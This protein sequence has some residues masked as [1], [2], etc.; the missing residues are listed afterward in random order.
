MITTRYY[1]DFCPTQAEGN[2][3]PAGWVTANLVVEPGRVK[4]YLGCPDHNDLVVTPNPA[5]VVVAPPEPVEV[6]PDGVFSPGLG[7]I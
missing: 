4:M 3:L 6:K 7:G 5:P 1:C 2:S